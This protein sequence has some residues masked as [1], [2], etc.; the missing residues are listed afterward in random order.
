MAIRALFQLLLGVVLTGLVQPHPANA[1]VPANSRQES[2]STLRD[3][4]ST[5]WK[6]ISTPYFAVV[7]DADERD[8]RRT[9]KD[10]E[11]VRTA[12]LTLL[13]TI[14][15]FG[16]PPTVVLLRDPSDR[17]MFMRIDGEGQP[18]SYNRGYYSDRPGAR[19]IVMAADPIDWRR[20]LGIP[21]SNY[22]AQL[23]ALDLPKLPSWVIR[24]V[25]ALVTDAA[26]ESFRPESVLGRPLES[27]IEPL[28]VDSLFPV[29][30]LIEPEKVLA[31]QRQNQRLFDAESWALLHF[32]MVGREQRSPGQLLNYI[33]AV[34]NGRPASEAFLDAFGTS[35]DAVQTDLAKYALQQSFPVAPL[36]E[37]AEATAAATVPVT[38][39][40]TS[41]VEAIQ[42]HLLTYLMNYSEAHGLLSAALA[43]D[44]SSLLARTSLTEHAVMHGRYR[45]AADSIRPVIAALPNDTGAYV[46]LGRALFGLRDFEGAFTAFSK[47]VSLQDDEASVYV[48]TSASAIALNKV[49][50]ADAAM[51]SA[52][53]IWGTSAYANRAQMMWAIGKD[54]E[55]LR[56]AQACVADPKCGT[57]PIVY[58]AFIGALSARRLGRPDEA[59]VILKA[60]APRAPAPWAT[61]VMAFLQG[62]LPATDLLSRARHNG[63][64]TEAHAYVGLSASVA[65]RREEALEHLRWVR[66]RG[67]RAYTEYLASVGELER[68]ESATPSSR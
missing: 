20:L 19:F 52:L 11:T 21:V 38:P 29:A 14:H 68:L 15:T 2:A 66:D 61:S 51:N 59:D 57:S 31:L 54:T 43:R 3:F 39:M 41:E 53:R 35:V 63:E 49:P 46:Y 40:M 32:L 42:G 45:E 50:E 6:R 62:S 22:V 7:G 4:P 10:L 33:E 13:P 44:P 26:S 65:G 67:S 1:Q 9:L 37:T 60:A 16:M 5:T 56:D 12:L 18:L 30:D 58:S 8:L 47:A 25:L 34:R 17:T 36:P 55:A 24:G 28:R 27:R 64:A 23:M 48:F